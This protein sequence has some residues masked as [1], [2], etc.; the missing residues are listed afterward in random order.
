MYIA[1]HIKIKVSVRE[2][3]WVILFLPQQNIFNMN[4]SGN[5]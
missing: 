5:S 3:S 2:L 4:K 1:N